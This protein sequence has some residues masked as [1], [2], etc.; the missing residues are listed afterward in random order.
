MKISLV[1]PAYNAISTIGE[2]ITSIL[3]QTRLPDEILVID[4]GS[5]DDTGAH[6]ALDHPVIWV[7]RQKN[8]GLYG[9]LN[10][11]FAASRGS[12]ISVLDADD[13]WAK[14]KTAVQ[15]ALLEERSELS[16]VTGRIR[17]FACPTSTEAERA[18]WDIPEVPQPG[19]LL[20]A[21]II[22]RSA[23]DAL[24]PFDASLRVGAHLDWMARLREHRGGVHMLEETVLYRRIHTGSLSQRSQAR[25][26]DYLAVA[27]MAL[28]R[29]RQK[30][31]H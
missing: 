9:A 12:F 23:V 19:W 17:M 18:K 14:D 21:M 6:P 10:T 25:D 20:S 5:T 13:L 7:I 15:S 2:T 31:Q 27:R 1:I 24:G 8:T 29:K 26:R 11:G 3:E 22:R 28:Q 4:D 30:S 16:A